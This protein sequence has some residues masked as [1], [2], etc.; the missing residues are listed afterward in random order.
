MQGHL[1][2]SAFSI[3]RPEKNASTGCTVKAEFIAF[4]L[5]ERILV[6]GGLH[7]AATGLG[8]W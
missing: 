4:K 1:T 8:A 7:F 2:C 6:E 3:W 5:W